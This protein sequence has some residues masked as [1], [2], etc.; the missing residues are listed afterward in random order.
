MRSTYNPIMQEFTRDNI[1][2]KILKNNS[3]CADCNADNP[4]WASL[5]L[6]VF[7]CI[8][9]SGVHRSLG[10]HVSKVIIN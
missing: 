10:V 9:C 6:G 3:F 2:R 7:L 8:E 5:N 4:D 1:V